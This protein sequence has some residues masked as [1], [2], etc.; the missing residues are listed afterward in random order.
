VLRKLWFFAFLLALCLRAHAGIV[1]DDL[2]QLYGHHHGY[3]FDVKDERNLRVIEMVMLERPKPAPKQ[4]SDVIF[5][6]KLSKEF[7][8]QYE[9]RFGSTQAEQILNTPSRSDE[10]TFST[11]QNVTVTEHTKKQRSFGE[12]MGR[13]LV[14]YHV[15]NWAKNDPDFRPVYQV[16]ERVSNVNVNVRP[17][18]KFKWKYNLAGPNMEFTL[19]NPYNV[20]TRIRVDMSGI[21]SE[22]D[23]AT[24]ILG[25]PV[26][27]K[28]RISAL[29]KREDGLYQLVATRKLTRNLS[30]SLTGSTDTSD[31][32]SSVKQDL[33]L[34]GFSWSE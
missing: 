6:E 17:G 1:D 3:L 2:P 23:E 15:D 8:N 9:R 14:E 10:Y 29:Y 11:G 27:N 12:Y 5:N 33:V 32:G 28:V 34:L 19:E 22:P 24:Y 13:K 31:A 25:Y 30:T 7:Q 16:K 26:T 21:V 18:Y 20:E 4:L